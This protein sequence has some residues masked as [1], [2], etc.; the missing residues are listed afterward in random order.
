MKNAFEFWSELDEEQK[1][2][3]LEVKA[4]YG[5]NHWWESDNPMVVLR[6]QIEEPKQVVYVPDYVVM[7]GQFLERPVSHIEIAF[8]YDTIKKDV[9]L[10][11]KRRESGIEQ[12]DEQK[13]AAHQDYLRRIE[14]IVEENLPADRVM[15]V[16]TSQ[17]PDRNDGG[18]DV[19]GYDG[20]LKP[21]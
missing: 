14:D 4:K 9:R 19:S 2:V 12:S 11:I 3:L 13:E 5:D 8:D 18:I 21:E 15:K 10:A 7:L 16:N 1:K 20:W 17:K 6:Y